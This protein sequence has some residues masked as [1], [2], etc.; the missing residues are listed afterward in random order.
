[1]PN[2][3]DNLFF[4]N[5]VLKLGPEFK[6]QYSEM[7][8]AYLNSIVDL[9][10]N[11][12]V[13]KDLNVSGLIKLEKGI[14]NLYTTPFKLDKSKENYITFASRS[15][16]VPYIIFSLVSKVPDSIIPI[17]ENNKD[18]NI[19]GDL[20]VNATSSG[21]GSFGTVSYTHLTLPTNACV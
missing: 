21:F 4:D 1:M 6:V 20:D 17:S 9:K 3:L 12:G 7:V 15:G 19:S 11:G 5:L 13:G 16:V 2:Y 14:A 10:I 18:L 8:Q